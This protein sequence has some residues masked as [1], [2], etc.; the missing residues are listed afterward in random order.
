M[1]RR[2]ISLVVLIL[3]CTATSCVTITAIAVAPEPTADIERA[4][5]TV[6]GLVA[7]IATRRG[8]EPFEAP[9]REEEG[10]RSCFAKQGIRDPDRLT[11]DLFVCGK[12]KDREIQLKLFQVMTSRLTPRADSL[13]REL[14]DSLSAE[15]GEPAVRECEWENDHDRRR[16]GCPP[17]TRTDGG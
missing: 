16:S 2:T 15:F 17:R 5:Q 14:L 13:R 1:L 7:R 3:V 12:V 8:L 9:D 6:L 4:A 11:T 10:W